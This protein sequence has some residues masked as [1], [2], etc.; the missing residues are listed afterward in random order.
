[1]KSHD[2][3]I[4]TSLVSDQRNRRWFFLITEDLTPIGDS[5][6]RLKWSFSPPA[7]SRCHRSLSAE[8]WC[9]RV[10]TAVFKRHFGTF[11]QTTTPPPTLTHR[12]STSSLRVGGMSDGCAALAGVPAGA[13]AI[14][15]SN[16]MASIIKF[17]SVLT[18][19]SRNGANRRVPVI[20]ASAI[21]IS[22]PSERYLTS[23]IF[24]RWPAIGS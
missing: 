18:T 3:R 8:A 24:A 22:R 11:W 17:A 4:G 7:L 6:S 16:R 9:G 14:I 15:V 20:G 23:G 13:G 1:M 19:D 2:L 5:C 12:S 10:G 21:S